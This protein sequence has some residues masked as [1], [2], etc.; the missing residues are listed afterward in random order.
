MRIDP[1]Q[2]GLWLMVLGIPCSRALTEIGASLLIATWA[3]RKWRS[4]DWRFH[5]SPLLVPLGA[6]AIW[7]ALSLVWTPYWPL[8]L[9]AVISQ[10]IEY[11]AIYLAISDGLRGRQ[12]SQRVIWLWLLWSTIMVTDGFVQLIRGTDLL[13]Q[14]APGVLAGGARMTAAMKYP[15]DFGAYVGLSAMMA[16]GVAVAERTQ[17]RWSASAV[18]LSVA[19]VN[20]AALVLTFSRG[21]WL[22]FALAGGVALSLYRTRYAIPLLAITV[23]LLLLLSPSLF[24]QR[25]ASILEVHPG[26]ATQERL[27]IWQSVF[28]M[29][30]EHPWIGFGLNTFDAVFPTYKHP[31]IYGTPY[32]HNCFL[33]LTAELGLIGLALF[34][35]ILIRIFQQ[36]GRPG[37]RSGWERCVAIPLMGAAA[38]YV[39]QSAVETNWYSLPLAV[40]WWATIGLIDSLHGLAEDRQQRFTQT[41]RRLV[42]IRTDRLGD[43]LMNLPALKALRQRFPKTEITLMVRPPLDDFLRGQPGID[44]IQPHEP[45]Y[46]QPWLGP[47]RWAQALRRGRF[48]AAV[49]LNPTKQAHLA[50]FLA[51]IPIRVGYARKWDWALTDTLPDQKAQRDRHEIEYNLEL[52]GMLGASTADH[53]PQLV[54]DPNDRRIVGHLLQDAGLEG[55]RPLVAIHP[56]TSDPGKQWPLGLVAELIERLGADG[57]I[58]LALIGGPEEEERARHFLAGLRVPI[59]SFVGRLS[60]RQLAALLAQCRVLV[61]NDSGPVHVAAAVGTRTVTL[62]TG[63]RP[64]ATPRRWG[65]VGPGHIVLTSRHPEIP[66]SVDEVVGAIHRQVASTSSII[67]PK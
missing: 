47:W 22:G 43:V 27:A 51:G 45:S 56:W 8:T 39:V 46:T 15:N 50:T 59:A 10:T 63:Q 23:V 31:T 52:V 11:A 66:I 37:I 25:L 19:L 60:L 26:S 1:Y 40:M 53:R 7:A 48:D 17:Q 9:R 29:I 18:A 12:Q 65:P 2:L 44:R 67:N 34:G 4:G 38:G 35:W 55:P 57:G 21:A 6:F 61:S 62:F 13:R 14:Y 16:L 36:A 28:G 20:G 42:A 24:F 3:F 64:A 41:I 54:I 30:R 32:A 5:R 58:A 49:I 33:Q